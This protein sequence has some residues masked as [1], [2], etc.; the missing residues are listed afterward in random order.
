MIDVMVTRLSPLDESGGYRIIDVLKFFV[1]TFHSSL[2]T[3]HSQPLLA[4][5]CISSETIYGA[6]PQRIADKSV[7][8]QI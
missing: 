6:L 2:F 8:V 4:R 1:L 3:P 5:N 7:G